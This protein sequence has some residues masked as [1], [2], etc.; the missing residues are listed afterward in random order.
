[1]LNLWQDVQAYSFSF[2]PW[3]TVFCVGLHT[4]NYTESP[5]CV[6]LYLLDS[7]YVGDD[8]WLKLVLNLLLFLRFLASFVLSHGNEYQT[9]RNINQIGLTV[10]YST[11][12]SNHNCT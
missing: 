1:M 6:H 7:M 3:A 11:E 10:Y 12:G 2:I 9:R 5:A 8:T 4:S